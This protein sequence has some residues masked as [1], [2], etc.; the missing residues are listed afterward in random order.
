MLNLAKVG[1]GK[2][3]RKSPFSLFSLFTTH[4]FFRFD[5]Q[6]FIARLHPDVQGRE[7]IRQNV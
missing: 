3:D 1:G 7:R 4:G 6:L 5:F 2:V